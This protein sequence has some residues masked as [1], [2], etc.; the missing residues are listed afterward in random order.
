MK[1]F[2]AGL[3]TAIIIAIASYFGITIT[4]EQETVIGEFNC[5]IIGCE[6]VEAAPVEP[7]SAEDIAEIEASV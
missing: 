2:I 6:E 3:V 5:N 7:A 1:Q 4:A